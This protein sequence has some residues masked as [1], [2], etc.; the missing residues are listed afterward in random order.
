MTSITLQNVTGMHNALQKVIYGEI[1]FVIVLF[2]LLF[3]F[4]L[5]FK[6]KGI[7]FAQTKGVEAMMTLTTFVMLFVIPYLSFT[8]PIIKLLLIVCS[9][10]TLLGFLLILSGLYFLQK[11]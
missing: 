1:T 11:D 4:N 5:L 7:G 2:L 8:N 6:N 10:S 3:L 9:I